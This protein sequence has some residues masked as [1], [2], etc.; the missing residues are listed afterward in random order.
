MTE[1]AAA[2]RTG[3]GVRATWWY[4]WSSIAVMVLGLNGLTALWLG[5]LPS[6]PIALRAGLI[7]LVVLN[8]ILQLR[9]SL[10]HRAGLWS[11]AAGTR[12]V[13]TLLVPAALTS[14]LCL[15]AAPRLL[16]GVLPLIVALSVLAAERPRPWCAPLSAAVVAALIVHGTVGSRIDPL[17]GDQPT[18]EQLE[19]LAGL[20]RAAIYLA[21][22]ALLAI[23]AGVWMW[24]VVQRLDEARSAEADLAVARERLR[25]AADLHDIQG[26]HLQV[27]ALQA[28]LAE[29]L[30][31]RDPDAARQKLRETREIARQAL[32][33]TRSLV[34]G[35]RQ[36]SL[37]QEL[38]NAADVLRA[39]GIDCRRRA[40]AEPQDP[41]IRQALGLAVRE[42]TTNILRHASAGSASYEV[43][44]EATGA[45][46]GTTWRLEIVN[47][48]ADA[49]PSASPGTGLQGLRERVESLNGTL[50]AQ[51]RDGRF[52]LEILLPQPQPERTTT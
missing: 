45:H 9:F 28:E 15:A 10:L 52:I 4:T 3:R 43:F 17:L 14:L 13:V 1:T 11:G 26:H 19:V 49:A 50:T 40:E 36:V 25:F 5:L 37:V 20:D 23:L 8:A 12:T 6:V 46:D 34:Q 29:R 35:L 39:A 22:F 31:E 7:A 41:Q 21:L 48:G 32:E 44:R 47:D 33:E 27:I 38:D 42:A 2:P 18:S 16:A 51:H 24:G 30:L